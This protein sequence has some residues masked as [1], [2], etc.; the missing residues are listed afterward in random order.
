MKID[1]LVCETKKPLQVLHMNEHAHSIWT[2][3]NNIST[4]AKLFETRW[5]REDLEGCSKELYSKEIGYMESVFSMITEYAKKISQ[6]AS[7]Q[8]VFAED[9]LKTN[10]KIPLCAQQEYLK[11]TE[12]THEH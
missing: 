2:T 5:L 10:T 8:I 6:L 9:F 1:N 11:K 12:V 3:C 7:E 4:L